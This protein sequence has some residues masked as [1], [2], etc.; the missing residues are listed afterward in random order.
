MLAE[1]F[2]LEG[3]VAI[4]TGGGQGLGKVFC[5]AFAEAGADVVVAEINPTTGQQT[6]DDVARLERRAL[7]IETDV[8]SRES[9]Q[10]MVSAALGEFGQ[11]DVLMNNAGIVKWCPAEEVPE[12]DWREVMDVNLN[13]LF[14]CCQEVG[15]H[16]I[17]RRR[18]SIIN[19]ASMSGL[20]VNRPQ[21]QTSYNASKAAVIQLTKSL[22]VE[23]APHN[24][25]V[26]AMAPGYM[27]T[28]MAK[29]FFENPEYGPHW[30]GAIPMKRPGKP[31]ELGPAAVFLASDASSYVTG[32]TLVVDG[33]YTAL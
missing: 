18:G 7:A 2:S 13:G 25:R 23:W 30:I 10:N 1:K 6:V 11:I 26:N 33:G 4:V 19:I 29:P 14:L 21:D 16:M 9:V 15:K 24:I 20:I 28:D 31:E 32:A 22:A 8:R 17:E 5:L 12:E 3:Q 27:G